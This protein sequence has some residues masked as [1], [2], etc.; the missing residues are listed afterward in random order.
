MSTGEDLSRLGL[1]NLAITYSDNTK[2][3]MVEGNYNTIQDVCNVDHWFYGFWYP[4]YYHTNIV[5]DKTKKAFNITKKLMDLKIVKCNTVKQFVDMV[6]IIL[7][8]L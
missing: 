3:Y 6:D 5:E 7:K 2:D 1:Q 4:Y 8:E